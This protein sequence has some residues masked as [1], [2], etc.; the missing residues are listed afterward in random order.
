VRA[1]S[2]E[3]ELVASTSYVS[4]KAGTFDFYDGTKNRL[5]V[6]GSASWMTSPDD[7]FKFG[8]SNDTAN[9]TVGAQFRFDV[10]DIHTKLLSPDGAVIVDVNNSKVE[11]TGDTNIVGDTIISKSLTVGTAGDA[12]ATP[13]PIYTYLY[14][15]RW[16]GD[17]AS[18]GLIFQGGGDGVGGYHSDFVVDNFW[19]N[20]RTYVNATSARAFIFQNIGTGNCELQVQGGV[21]VQG[22]D[23]FN[24][25]A[26]TAQLTVG[27][28]DNYI[29]ATYADLLLI[30]GYSGIK[31][32]DLTTM[33][34]LTLFEGTIRMTNLP[35]TDPQAIY[36]LWN[37]N[38]TLK[39]SAG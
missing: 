8:V 17:H 28:G 31:F 14:L 2:D 35:T 39:I 33:D 29:R 6:N 13:T 12:G 22:H 34:Y 19:G 24:A 11:V 25:I 26:E 23:G 1:D 20:L 18:T 38:G 9:V 27:D 21:L 37:D 30:H 36:E 7:S 10:T 4:V 15:N 32:S 16:A 5:K 3:V